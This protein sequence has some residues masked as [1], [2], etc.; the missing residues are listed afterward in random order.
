V[1]TRPPKLCHPLLDACG[2]QHSFGAR[3]A[4]DPSG[5]RR[6]HQVHGRVVAELLDDGGLVPAEAD[7][8]VSAVAEVAI[9]VVTADCV[10]IL[11]ASDDGEVVAAIHA[12]WRGLAAGVV[13]AG[14]AALRT[15]AR[16][17]ASLVAVIGPHIGV[18]CYEVDVP[19][20][21]AMAL[22]FGQESRAAVQVGRPGHAHLD[23]GV[24]AEL[25]LARAEIPTHARGR[26]PNAC[27]FCHPARYH[28]YRRD[29]EQAGRLVHYVAARN[30]V[31]CHGD[32]S[33]PEEM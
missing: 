2:V 26:I 9:A 32:D 6:P 29:G 16:E 22:H 25:A 1:S 31:N 5:L 33:N 10:P 8:V 3:G 24:L 11:A 14:V 21:D 12:G 4:E 7:A 17:D 30:P 23:L 28:S 18:C 15:R 20:L 19:V 27:T 13:E